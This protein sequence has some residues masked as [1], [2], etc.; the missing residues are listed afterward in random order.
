MYPVEKKYQPITYFIRI[1]F[2][3][4]KNRKIFGI[5]FREWRNPKISQA[6]KLRKFCKINFRD[7]GPFTKEKNYNQ[8]IFRL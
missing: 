2:R 8:L 7:Q 6:A 4:E 1:N 5:K 3:E